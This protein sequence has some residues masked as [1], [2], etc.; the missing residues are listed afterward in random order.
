MQKKYYLD[1]GNNLQ[2]KKILITGATDGIGYSIAKL[3]YK[4]HS[5]IILHGTSAASLEN[6]K[7]EFFNDSNVHT[8]SGDLKQQDGWQAVENGI[9]NHEPEVLILNAGYNCKKKYAS[10]W[11][12][13]EILEMLNVNFISSIYCVRTFLN[14]SKLKEHRKLVL[15]LSSSCFFPREQLSY[16]ITL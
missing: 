2:H 5:E 15:I 12:D 8:I 7:A 6:L 9:K 4:N 1:E 16:H 13:H 3:L 14:L 10:K 11:F